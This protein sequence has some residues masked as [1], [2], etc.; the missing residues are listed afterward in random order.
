MPEQLPEVNIFIPTYN[1]S[2][3]I[4]KAIDSA[5][6]QDYKNIK[7]IVSDDSSNDETE[8]LV[9][10]YLND[11]RFIYYHN[12]PSLGKAKNYRTLL[13]EY[14]T[15]EW[16]ANLDGDDHYTDQKFISNAINTINREG[17]DNVLFY[18][19]SQVIAFPDKTADLLPK[20]PDHETVMTAGKYVY[21]I[22]SIM[23]FSHLSTL[24]NAALAKS[25]GFYEKEITSSD[26]YSFY[27]LCLRHAAMKVII[28]KNIVGAWV[29]HGGNESS[30]FSF[31][32]RFE[33]GLYYFDIF[34]F[35]NK[36]KTAGILKNTKWL[37]QSLLLYWGSYFKRLVIKKK[38]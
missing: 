30:N 24:Y 23:H 6:M 15:G 2:H 21:D 9:Q 17:K 36:H 4:A 22:Y 27:K 35:A 20:L 13:Y 38:Y 16:V 33:N 29:Q 19:A 1:Q 37:S 28:S 7:V 32:Q 5:L 8:T 34:R 10:K 11:P 31:K 26:M 18:M 3:V 25:S 12:R 14:S